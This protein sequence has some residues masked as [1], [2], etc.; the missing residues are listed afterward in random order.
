MKG[1]ESSRGPQHSVPLHVNLLL[2]LLSLLSLYLFFLPIALNPPA[3]SSLDP[4][5]SLYPSKTD[6]TNP[7]SILSSTIV[8][9]G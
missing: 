6:P 3:E 9:F 2:S 5:S 1:D 7:Y 4:L 8:G